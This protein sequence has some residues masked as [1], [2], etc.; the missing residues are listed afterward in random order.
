MAEGIANKWAKG[1]EDRLSGRMLIGPAD[2][3][4]QFYPIRNG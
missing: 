4:I 1:R 2:N 3:Y